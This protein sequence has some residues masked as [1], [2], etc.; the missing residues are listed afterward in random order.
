LDLF[1]F[2]YYSAPKR[3][4][5]TAGSMSGTSDITQQSIDLKPSE[6]QVLGL[7][8]M[9]RTLNPRRQAASYCLAFCMSLLL[10]AC[11][12]SPTPVTLSRIAISPDPIFV[13]TATTLHLTA[14][15]TYSNKSSA[16]LTTQV[17]WKSADPQTASVDA[18]GLVTA[19]GAIGATTTVT[20]SLNGI[21]S[22]AVSVTVT[23]GGSVSGMYN[24]NVARFDHTATL[25][26]DGRVLV[27]GGYGTAI[28]PSNGALD[29]SEIYDPLQQT[30]TVT[31]QPLTTGRGDHT[32]T[33]LAS[34]KVL[35]AGGVDSHGQD[36]LYGEL[37]DPS[38]GSTGTWTETVKLVNPRSYHTA[39]LLKDGRV[40]LVGGVNANS[41]VLNSAEIYD[42][43]ANTWT[44]TGSLATPRYSHTA[45]L[46]SDGKVLVVGGFDGT[47][48]LASAEI[49][50]PTSGTWTTTTST[51]ASARFLHTA[52]LLANTACIT[53]QNCQVLVAGGLNA[54]GDV[55]SAELFDPGTNTWSSTGSLG[56]AR[57]G[58]I[59]TLMTSGSAIGQVMVMG[60]GNASSPNLSSVELYDPLLRTWSGTAN[61]QT[62]RVV[63]TATLLA[64]GDKVLVA[65]GDGAAGPLFSVELHN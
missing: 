23:N 15:G 4:R 34:G 44:A 60:G 59:A 39:T 8:K 21:V 37:Y 28:P 27:A 46:L 1:K 25:L 40:L 14:T 42:P 43:M 52:T 7:F 6:I 35:V 31:L 33:L 19:V 16:D 62:G 18:S 11:G 54:N 45:T 53:A 38:A 64:T 61:L 49:F 3:A 36:A 9:N 22:P 56:I 12:G 13:G 55:A 29:S 30:W 17:T 10:A 20:A 47:S 51:L 57:F 50:D 5:V 2:K 58:H 41:N 63:F 26:L 32:A 65:G 48:A 24:L